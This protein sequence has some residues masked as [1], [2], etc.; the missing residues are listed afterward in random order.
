[1]R[2]FGLIRKIYKNNENI[3]F[4]I[5]QIIKSKN[6]SQVSLEIEEKLDEF[7]I[8]S[9]LSQTFSLI[10]IHDVHEKCILLNNNEEYFIS[11]IHCEK[12]HN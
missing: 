7:F 11:I 8:I 4:L 9:S 12:D 2:I 10:N 1:L 3:F 5:Q 6:F